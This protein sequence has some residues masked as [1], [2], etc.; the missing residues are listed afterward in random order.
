MC[1]SVAG[2]EFMNLGLLT[3]VKKRE[4]GKTGRLNKVLQ[5]TKLNSVFVS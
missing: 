5:F 3:C 1:Y 2:I 4:I